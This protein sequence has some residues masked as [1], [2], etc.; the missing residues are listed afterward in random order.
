MRNKEISPLSNERDLE[1]QST[2]GEKGESKK[3]KEASY[4]DGAR[5]G[6][7][8]AFA[9]LLVGA[10]GVAAFQMMG[11]REGRSLMSESSDTALALRG[12]DSSSLTP[13]FSD[14]R[15]QFIGE[16]LPV[17]PPNGSPLD[18]LWPHLAEDIDKWAREGEEA[19]RG[20]H[21]GDAQGRDDGGTSQRAEKKVKIPGLPDVR[22]RKV[23][24]GEKT[25]RSVTDAHPDQ[26]E[27]DK[28]ERAESLELS[29]E[30]IDSLKSFATSLEKDKKAQQG[31]KEILNDKKAMEEV[32]S[33]MGNKEFREHALLELKNKES[34]EQAVS[35]LKDKRVIENIKQISEGMV[36]K[37]I[38]IE[39]RILPGSTDYTPPCTENC[40]NPNGLFAIP[41]VILVIVGVA[42]CC[43]KYSRPDASLPPTRN[44]Q[45]E[46]LRQGRNSNEVRVR[47]RG[48]SSELLSRINQPLSPLR[49]ERMGS[50]IDE[51]ARERAVV[52]SMLDNE[53]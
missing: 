42:Y 9:G 7:G 3:S 36:T 6:I 41:A 53:R 18:K 37:D 38:K 5:R 47:P 43:C 16:S 35:L 12:S 10:T 19:S 2:S 50:R 40:N 28:S 51:E 39:R 27:Q 33:L 48:Y 20:L 44:V 26:L 21:Q 24:P 31:L 45:M 34:V 11:D 52:R 25:S 32:E 22:S 15:T 49:S 4:S 17:F 30:E 14:Q 1:K 8:I 13:A 23:T 46:N 29:R